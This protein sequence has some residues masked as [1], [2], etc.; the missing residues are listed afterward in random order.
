MQ[1]IVLLFSWNTQQYCSSA[2]SYCFPFLLI[3]CS[4]H[5]QYFYR[6]RRLWNW[7]CIWFPLSWSYAQL[8]R[9]C[10][11]DTHRSAYTQTEY[12]FNWHSHQ[13]RVYIICCCCCWLDRKSQHINSEV[14]SF[15]CFDLSRLRVMKTVKPNEQNSQSNAAKIDVL[16]MC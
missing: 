11:K 5:L 6:R 4:L 10:K 3:L 15:A 14:D 1:C 9:G 16:L 8:V 12:A 13:N 2:S 7:V